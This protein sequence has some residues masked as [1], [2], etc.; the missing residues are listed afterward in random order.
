MSTV[1]PEAESIETE[2][3]ATPPRMT[4]LRR[5]F[6]M[7]FLVIS[8]AVH[9]V[10]GLIAAV[11][12]VQQYNT[13]RKLTFQSGPPSPNRAT[14]SIEHKV[15]MAKKQST[16]TAPAIKRI[17]STGI[18][19]VTLPEMPSMPTSPTSP[20]QMAGAGGASLGASAGPMTA[21]GGAAGG[22]LVSMFGLREASGGLKGEFYDLKQSPG[23]K[24]TGMDKDKYSKVVIEFVKSG[25]NQAVLNPY[26][27]ASKPL[28][29]SQFLIPSIKAD[30]GPKAFQVE[31]DVKPSLWL[32]WY[33]G[34]VIPSETGT[35]YFVGAGDDV[36]CVRF[37]GNSVLSA[38]F[39]IDNNGLVRPTA[40]YDYGWPPPPAWKQPGGFSKGPGIQVEAGKSY[41][42]EV[43]IGEQPGGTFHAILLLEK[44][45][46]TYK[47]DNHGNPILPVFRMGD[48]KPIALKQ[49]QTLPP[50]EDDGPIWRGTSDTRPTSA[51]DTLKK[52]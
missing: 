49:G 48:S 26:Y 47:K 17:V 7:R 42:I 33:K 34:N 6:G 45:G 20:N 16:M 38:N 13:A 24:D 39:D 40:H 32:A 14:R 4:W 46:G 23:R 35:F 52:P 2:A 21:G 27:K 43:L 19:K 29:S 31:R 9:V 5:V 18:S 10:L 51:L 30:E 28:Y 12:V 36:L 44:Q 25:W 11:W 1:L 37:N 15:Q 22:S 3:A 41:P 50:H 8:I